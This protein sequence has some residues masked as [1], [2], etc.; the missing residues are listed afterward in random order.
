MGGSPNL[1]ITIFLYVFGILMVVLAVILLLQAYNVMIPRP[2]VWAMVL[3]AIG[4]GVLAG[5]R[6][7]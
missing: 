6:S 5:V 3:L 4:L 2:A 1:A 7:R